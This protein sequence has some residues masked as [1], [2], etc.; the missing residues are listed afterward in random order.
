MLGAAHTELHWGSLVVIDIDFH[1]FYFTIKFGGKIVKDWAIILQGPHHGAQKSTNTGIS[2]CTTVVSKSASLI[3][4]T[5]LIFV[6][7]FNKVL[8][9]QH[10]ML[11]DVVHN[12][13]RYIELHRLVRLIKTNYLSCAKACNKSALMSST[14]SKPTE[15]RNNV[16]VIPRATRSASGISIWVWVAG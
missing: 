3:C 6:S 7:L 15:K 10:L 11:I 13:T 12:S 14:S 4:N 2:D 8:T 9:N 16:F 5:S 1:N